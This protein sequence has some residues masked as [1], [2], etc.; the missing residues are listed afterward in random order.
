MRGQ[1]NFQGGDVRYISL[2]KRVPPQHPMRKTPH[3]AAKAKY[4]TIDARRPTTGACAVRKRMKAASGWAKT[5][6]RL[7]K[8][9][10]NGRAKRAAQA[11]RC[12]AAYNRVRRGAVAGWLDAHHG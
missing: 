9:Q 7:A 12:L 2:K 5:V 3:V 1:S 6:G 8:T 10:L 11:L 4:A